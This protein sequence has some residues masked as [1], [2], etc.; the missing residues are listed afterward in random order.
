MIP[1][2]LSGLSLSCQQKGGY[3]GL[4]DIMT[5]LHSSEN[6]GTEN[7]KEIVKIN[8]LIINTFFMI[9]LFSFLQLVKV[10]KTFS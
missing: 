6:T 10:P 2:S 8:T 1:V 9:A 5:F 7:V 4:P 3:L